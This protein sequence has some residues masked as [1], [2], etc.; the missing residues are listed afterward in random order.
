MRKRYIGFKKNSYYC[1]PYTYEEVKT[2]MEEFTGSKFDNDNRMF[3]SWFSG[4]LYIMQPFPIGGL[5]YEEY[6]AAQIEWG[7]KHLR[8]LTLK[9]GKLLSAEKVK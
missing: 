6:K 7:L 4:S 5:S 8:K 2:K 1:T 9:N 3:A